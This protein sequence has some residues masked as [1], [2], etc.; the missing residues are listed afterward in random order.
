M[1]FKEKEK[2]DTIQYLGKYFPYWLEF[3]KKK[4][5]DFN[6]FGKLILDL[7]ENKKEAIN[8]FSEII[9]PLLECG[10]SIAVVPPH[11]KEEIE[12]GIKSL[13]INLT[14]K[15]RRDAT[16]CLVRIKDINKLSHGGD[17]SIKIH[18]ES[19]QINDKEKIEEQPVLLMDDI[20]T[21]ENSV[22]ACK[23]ILED[24]RA[25]VIGCLVLGKTTKQELILDS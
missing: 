11:G 24:N 14:I 4:N 18:L 9:D 17:R 20:A 25:L 22:L 19:I 3:G 6:K 15:N 23:K 2:N 5:P 10:I 16:N 8:Y 21:S 1:I 12:T 13:A 7:K